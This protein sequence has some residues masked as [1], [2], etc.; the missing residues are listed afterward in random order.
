[1]DDELAP[2]LSAADYVA[3]GKVHII[4][5]ASGSVATIKVPNIAESLGRNP[6]VS[7]RIVLTE[8]ASRFLAGQSPEQPSLTAL[9]R[10]NGVDGVYQDTDE[11]KTPWT[12]GTKILH[13]ELRR[14]AHLM[15]AIL[16]ANT[17]AKMTMGLSDNLL[18]SVVRAW[19]STG[20][21]DLYK[22]RKPRIFAAP[23]MNSAMWRHPITEKHLQTLQEWGADRD[24]EGGWI[25]VLKPMEKELACGDI[26]DGAMRDW[27]EIVAHVESYIRGGKTAIF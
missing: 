12:R 16:S 14:W 1:M 25:T 7:I 4:I 10:I 20:T 5:A 13:I 26:G 18:L 27:K 17:L 6:N 24:D 22:S 11:W 23:S 21:I 2:P 15:V 3:D 19:D 9:R 8:S